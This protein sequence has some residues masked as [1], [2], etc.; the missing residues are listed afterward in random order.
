MVLRHEANQT[1]RYRGLKIIKRSIF[2]FIVM[3]VLAALPLSGCS[4]QKAATEIRTDAVID[5]RTNADGNYN[6]IF[7]T[8]DQERYFSNYPDGAVYKARQLLES[9]GATFEKHYICSNV[10]T[11]SRSVIYTGQHITD[12]KMLDNTDLPWQVAL[13]PSMT[14]VGDM[15]REAGYYTAYKGKFHLGDAGAVDLFGSG[16]EEKTPPQQQDALEEYGF[17]DWNPEGELGGAPLQGFE[18]DRRIEGMAS[19]WLRSKGAELNKAGQ[20]FFLA[21]NLI[22]PHDVMYFNTAAEGGTEQA[23]NTVMKLNLE[24]DHIIY[25]K[26]YGSVPPD[27][28][29]PLDAPGRVP[30]HKEYYKSWSMVTGPLPQNKEDIERFNDYYFNCIQDNDDTLM[31]LLSDIEALGLLDNTI[32][33]FTADH[34]E[35]AGN[36]GLKGKGGFM[37]EENIHVP[38]IIC[39]PE[40]EGGKRISALTSHLDLATTF[41]GMTG[42]PQEE[43]N[44]IT[45]GLQGN[46]LMDLLNGAKEE[47]R[48]GALFAFEMVSVLDGDFNVQQ[49]GSKLNFEKRGFVRGLVTEQY[50]FTRYFSPLHFNTPET[51]EELY[52]GN[53]VELF[54]LFAD[55]RELNN[56]AA[57]PDAHSELIMELNRQLN[58][59]IAK[60]IGKDD[61]EE[62][63]PVFS[64]FEQAYGG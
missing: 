49:A 56:L 20:S 39:H 50:K 35:M 23:G 18:A 4:S 46:N 24:P 25:K 28:Q 30:A 5:P 36:H 21:V 43:K 19:G 8:T 47:V 41:I 57:D 26:T 38:L 9:M 31:S 54:D 53:D 34:G 37:Y 16:E 32:I 42:L 63:K 62:M 29:E 61:G 59:L 7:I 6:I 45:E 10:S 3:F 52:A 15:M 22:N 60:E 64:F 11:S 51:I 40:Y 55:P 14:T 48:T 58:E 17:S 12:T 13:D 27:W 44:R 2:V 1:E 33:V